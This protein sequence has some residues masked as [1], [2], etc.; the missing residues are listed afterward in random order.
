M[1][2]FSVNLRFSCLDTPLCG[3]EQE[4]GQQWDGRNAWPPLQWLLFRGFRRTADAVLA[5]DASCAPS[6]VV[7]ASGNGIEYAQATTLSVPEPEFLC[8]NDAD[9]SSSPSLDTTAPNADAS[10]DNSAMLSEISAEEA[11]TAA[12]AARDLAAQ[13]E[14]AFFTGARGGW[15]KSRAMFEKYD[16]K[17]AGE[18]GGGGEYVLQ[19]RK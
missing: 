6:T 3:L 9:S 16:A 13:L 7:L 2:P 17:E 14:E 4:T 5:A 19:A 12:A 15:E 18:G 8:G 10:D 11:I 1:I